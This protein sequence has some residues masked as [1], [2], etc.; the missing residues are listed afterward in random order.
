VARVG[1]TPTAASRLGLRGSRIQTRLGLAGGWGSRA[2]I[3]WLLR[4]CGSWSQVSGFGVNK[5]VESR[6]HDDAQLLRSAR[7]DPAAFSVFYDRYERLVAGYLARRVRDPELVADL[8]GE[9]FASA[10]HA[11]HRYRPDEPSAVGWLL[12]IAHNTLANSVRRGQVEARARRRLGIREAVSFQDEELDRVEQ[13]LS[14]DGW[15][16]GLLDEL[17]DE[18]AEAVRARVI[19]ERDYLE[20]ADRLKTSELVIRKRVSR[21]LAALRRHVEK[22]MRP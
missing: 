1:S 21:G 13:L 19:D 18:Q 8:T 15:I 16:V 9:V 11:A 10:L 6:G 12:A 3:A 2:E 14:S 5:A 20:I 7:S 4:R 17:P 22:E